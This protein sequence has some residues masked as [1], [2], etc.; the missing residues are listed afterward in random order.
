MKILLLTRYNSLGPSSRLR[1]YQYLPYLKDHGIEIEVAPLLGS[2]YIEDL[3]WSKTRNYASVIRA[4]FQR[5]L[6]LTRSRCF[7]MI[8]IEY[9]ILP[10]LPEWCELILSRLNIPY[11]VDYDDAIF[12]RYEI[13]PNHIVRSFLRNKIDHVMGHADIVVAGNS[14]LADRAERAGAKRIEQLPTVIDLERYCTEPSNGGQTFKIGWIGTPST[15][16]YLR[17][18]EPAIS[19]ICKEPNTNL[20]LVGSGPIQFNGPGVEIRP[21]TEQTEVTDILDFDVGVM[22][23]PSNEWTRGKCGYKLIQYMAC[24]RSVVASR[25]GVNPEIVEDGVHGF[26]ADSQEEWVEAL[27]TLREN[28]QLRKEMGQ[29][30]RARVEKKYCIQVTAPKLLSILKNA[31]R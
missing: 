2:R 7:D 16:D 8:W 9:E 17:L 23:M 28:H 22:P 18:M 19:E 3:Y 26:L 15:A 21:W 4:Y 29:R 31:V 12:H 14:Y 27:Q 1:F 5:L 6:C 24:S 11:I 30:G 10:W 25:V 13:H 20:V